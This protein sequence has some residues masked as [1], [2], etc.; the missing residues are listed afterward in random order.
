MRELCPFRAFPSTPRPLFGGRKRRLG[1][2]STQLQELRD[3]VVELLDTAVD[4]LSAKENAFQQSTKE[5]A[6]RGSAA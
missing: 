2:N 4:N 5:S 3:N 1:M 6:A